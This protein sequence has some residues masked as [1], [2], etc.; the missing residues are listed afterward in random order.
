MTPD[1]LPDFPYGAVYFRKSN[2]PREDWARDYATAAEDGHTLFRHW[3][4][5]SAIEIE[6]GVFDWSDYD[7]QLDLAA[8]HGIKTI[9]A[10]MIAVAPEWAYRRYAHAR[11]QTSEGRR[12]G[13]RMHGS[14]AVGGGGGLCLDNEDLRAA[15]ERFLRALVT[16][17]RDHPGLGGYDIWNE[18][19]YPGDVCYCPATLANF[20]AWL[21]KR[22]VDLRTLGEAWRRYSF[23]TWED[24]TPPHDLGPYPDTLD[25]LQFRIDNAYA[26]LDWRIEVIRELDPDHPI[27]A[28]G[29]A[30]TLTGLASNTRDDWLAAGK[31]DSY[32][33]TWG[34]SR[35]GDEPWKQVHAVDLVRAAA[36][37]KPFWHAEA[38]AGPLWMQSNVLNK[39][40]DEGRIAEPE[41]IRYWDL[42]SFMCGATGLLYLRWRP[43]LDGPLF[44]AFGPYG[45]DGSRTDRS[46]MASKIAKWV[47]APEQKTLWQSRPVRGQVGILIAPETQHF[48]YAQQGDSTYYARSVQ[49][50][51]RG[52]FDNNV[53]ADFVR[54]EHIDEYTCLYLPIPVMLTQQTVGRLKTWVESGGTLISEGCPGYFD[55]HAHV[56]P[57]QPNLGLDRLFGVKEAYVEFTPDILDDLRV[58]VSGTSMWGGLFLQAYEPTTGTPVGWYEGVAGRANGQVAAVDNAVGSGGTRLIGTMAGYG[59]ATHAERLPGPGA[60]PCEPGGNVA[61][62]RNLVGWAGLK[63]HV[64]TSDPLIIARLHA[65]NGGTYLWVA[66][67]TRRDRPVRLALSDEWGPFD[68]AVP[69][70]G[71]EAAIAGQ[72]VVLTAPAR[73]V[74]VLAL[75]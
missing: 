31:V 24:V 36:R 3:F 70:W 74:T 51:H 32:G 30:G 44:G 47:A 61:L 64:E 41:D 34:S 29:V 50:A 4:L 66:N 72:K 2:P 9:I 33:Y 46:E 16:R 62:Y 20:R 17:Y 13:P 37:G 6:P 75:R 23:A 54:L 7:R 48:L 73:D 5:W 15:A 11:Y 39:P 19:N 1:P 68:E 40:R 42:V 56:G 43:L 8:E 57:T 69:L 14:C 28:H 18:G 52:F 22:Y 10:E 49:G 63:P 67:P 35:H 53:Q 26:Q 38:Y 59:H 60:V 55:G 58:N 45:M 21:R 27:T 25:W 12:P 65:G 71:A